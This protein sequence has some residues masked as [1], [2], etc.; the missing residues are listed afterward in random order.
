MADTFFT[1]Q[2][3]AAPWDWNPVKTGIDAYLGVR[4]AQMEAQE[5]E[6]ENQTHQMT[7][8]MTEQLMPLKVEAA[9]LEIDK[10]RNEAAEAALG[11]Q[12]TRQEMEKKQ[13]RTAAEANAPSYAAQI[14]NKDGYWG[15]LAAETSAPS[16]STAR[17][18]APV[19]AA[20][21]SPL[22]TIAQDLPA[23][24]I[25]SG[26]AAAEALAAQTPAPIAAEQSSTLQKV[27]GETPTPNKGASAPQIVPVTAESPKTL[28]TVA[29]QMTE[30]DKGPVKPSLLSL[31]DRWNL[32]D[33]DF[34][35]YVGATSPGSREREELALASEQHRL[36]NRLPALNF[37]GVTETQFETLRGLDRKLVEEFDRNRGFYPTSEEA[38][39]TILKRERNKIEGVA[40]PTESQQLMSQLETLGKEA[41]GTPLYN[42]IQEKI[43]KAQRKESGITA[44]DEYYSTLNEES[45]INFAKSARAPLSDGSQDYDAATR[46]VMG[47]R[48]AL[49]IDMLSSRDPRII[50][51]SP[52]TGINVG[53]QEGL[54]IYESAVEK[55]QAHAQKVGGRPLVWSGTGFNLLNPGAAMP[56]PAEQA[57]AAPA[58][59]YDQEVTNAATAGEIARAKKLKSQIDDL[60]SRSENVPSSTTRPF[61]GT[62]VGAMPR[63]V[64]RSAEEKQKMARELKGEAIKLQKELDDILKKYPN[65]LK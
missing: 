4:R 26:S 21:G 44:V 65:A 24:M 1:P 12:K 31:I 2:Y 45:S 8:R 55:A 61:Y 10:F 49:T 62:A 34:L 35:N 59:K 11:I 43:I 15:A 32:E 37:A 57:G 58:T 50:D 51:V 38:L 47:K 63:V 16:A 29:A 23:P 54:R 53:T 60:N 17:R 42:S 18:P 46:T 39:Q 52:T 9:R 14:F 30:E 13:W 64:D 36:N 40:A 27:A 5:N 33:R 6:R 41:I 48:A 56:Q 22:Q 28:E 19:P 25:A 20:T 3:A 7:M